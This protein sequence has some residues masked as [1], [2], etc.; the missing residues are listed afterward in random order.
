MILPRQLIL[1]F[2]GPCS[3]YLWS[4]T[5]GNEVDLINVKSNWWSP[6]PLT[7]LTNLSLFQNGNS[8]LTPYLILKSNSILNNCYVMLWP[9]LTWRGQERAQHVQGQLLHTCG[10]K[11]AG[12][13]H[14][15]E[16]LSVSI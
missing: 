14:V 6:L 2:I 5:T 16:L 8:R 1:V 15:M 9:A 4:I 3:D 11:A 13:H 7:N 12:S 10:M